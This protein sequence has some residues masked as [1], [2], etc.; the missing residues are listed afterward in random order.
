[1]LN[2]LAC[3]YPER[4]I[5]VA[6]KGC[7]PQEKDGKSVNIDLIPVTGSRGEEYKRHRGQI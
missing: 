6:K 3:R 2:E 7:L 1:M 5:E 4:A